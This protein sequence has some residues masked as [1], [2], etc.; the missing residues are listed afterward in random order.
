MISYLQDKTFLKRL[1][2]EHVK[3]ILV[4]I[5]LLDK[6][7]TPIKS[8]EGR[9]SGGNMS[10]NGNSAIRRSGSISFVAEETKNDLSDIDISS[11]NVSKT[12]TVEDQSNSGKRPR[13][14][15][16]TEIINKFGLKPFAIYN[17]K[18]EESIYRDKSY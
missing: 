3:N 13:F 2:K 6:D 9:I 7:E 5:I 12:E 4:R 16:D 14:S 17:I 1:D 15:I 8:I 11:I 10:I 18:K